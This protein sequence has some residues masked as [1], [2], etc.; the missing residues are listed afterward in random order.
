[1]G[2]ETVDIE[3]KGSE[4]FDALLSFGLGGRFLNCGSHA[5]DL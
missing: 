3:R 2:L 5:V 4:S 1:L